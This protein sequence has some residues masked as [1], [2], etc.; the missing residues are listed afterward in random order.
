MS[1][2]LIDSKLDVKKEVIKYTRS[3][4]PPPLVAGV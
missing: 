1:I 4:P 2:K 3:S